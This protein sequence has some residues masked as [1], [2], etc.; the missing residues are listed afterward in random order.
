LTLIY[1]TQ[2]KVLKVSF[3][4]FMRYFCIPENELSMLRPIC[5]MLTFYVMFLYN[6]QRL[7]N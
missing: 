7:E 3:S 5:S 4:A 6:V 1:E 2:R